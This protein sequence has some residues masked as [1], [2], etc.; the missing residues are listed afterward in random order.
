V[1][2]FTKHREAIRRDIEERGW[3]PNLESYT[4]VLGGDT[5]DATVLLMAF[6]GFDEASSPRMGR[7][8][9][10]IQEKLG[11]GPGLLYRYEQSFKGGEGVFALCSFW[12][13]EFLARGGG[14][15][16][17]AHQAFARTAAYANDLGLFAEEIDPKT[18]DALGNFPQAFTHVGLINAAL[19][20]AE[21][22][23][24]P[25]P[26]VNRREGSAPAAGGELLQP[27]V[28]R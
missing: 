21:R 19:S 25:R 3:N 17:A 2:Q 8:F 11:G 7:T 4:Q 12:I 16:E 24:Q 22:D 9:R 1:D 10:R 18:G 26:G 6:H 15:P 28:R 23:E 27:E 14:T 13:A 5:L 20:L